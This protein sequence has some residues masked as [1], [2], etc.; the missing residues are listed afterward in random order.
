MVSGQ[1]VIIIAL[2]IVSATI[3]YLVL[4]LTEPIKKDI[5]SDNSQVNNSESIP[6]SVPVLVLK[7]FPLDSSGTKLDQTITG[8]TIDL[9]TI[10]SKVNSLNQQGIEKLT[11]V[12]KYHGYKNTVEPSLNYSIFEE[13]EFLTSIPI[14]INKV[15][16][17]Q[18]TFRPDYTK[19]LNDA[20]ICDYVD[21]K[22]VKQVWV[23][24]YH[25]GNVE[26]AEADM[27]MGTNSQAYWNHGTYGDVSNSE[28]TNDMPTCQKTYTLYNYNYDRGLGELLEDHGHQIESLFSFVDNALWS[29]FKSPNGELPPTVNHCGWTHSPPNAGDWSGDRGQYD[30]GD[31]TDVLSDCEDW[32]PDGTGTVKTVDCHT[33]AGN[34]CD[35]FTAG[36]PN[37]AGVAFKVWWMQNIPGKNN[38][39][40]YDSKSLR[41]WWEFYGD[42]DN[43]MAKGKSLVS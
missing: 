3:S 28:Q 18:N 30:W 29:K 41:N 5:D 13:K 14:S 27:A 1:L 38:G 4:I 22:G 25:Y 12:T 32:K 43:A 7:Y 17:N 2:M 34:D 33:W 37:E 31:E 24:S 26:P 16:W 35:Q 39:L 40:T 15:P 10:R 9:A 36:K 8:M 11:I 23:W 6:I 20:N 42:F 21:N 19:I